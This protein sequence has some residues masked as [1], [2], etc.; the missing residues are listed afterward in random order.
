MQLSLPVSQLNGPLCLAACCYLLRSDFS[1]FNGVQ[2][3][4]YACAFARNNLLLSKEKKNNNKIKAKAHQ[5]AELLS[6]QKNK[7]QKGP[8][9]SIYRSICVLCSAQVSPAWT[10]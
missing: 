7:E 6:Q 1:F 9:F 5:A 4:Q 10:Q 3:P 2:V 8:A